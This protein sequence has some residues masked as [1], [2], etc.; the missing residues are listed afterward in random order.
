MEYKYIHIYTQKR[1]IRNP[2]FSH[3]TAPTFSSLQIYSPE[4]PKPSFSLKSQMKGKKDDGYLHFQLKKE[5]GACLVGLILH[6][7]EIRTL[8][9]RTL[10]L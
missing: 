3:F 6:F 2:S 4:G 1:G 7:L 8:N 5:K 9:F 10:E